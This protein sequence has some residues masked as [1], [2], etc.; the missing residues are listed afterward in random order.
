MKVRLTDPGMVMWIDGE[1]VHLCLLN[2]DWSAPSSAVF[3]GWQSTTLHKSR[4]TERLFLVYAES[5]VWRVSSSRTF[6]VIIVVVALGYDLRNVEK[7]T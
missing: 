2:T 7:E 5:V 3:T 4:S 1:L 6:G